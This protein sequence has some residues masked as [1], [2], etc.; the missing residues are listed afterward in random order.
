MTIYVK[1]NTSP[2][3]II[4][5]D[6]YRAV[7]SNKPQAGFAGVLRD[8]EGKW[9]M[10]C[11]GHYQLS[12]VIDNELMTLLHGLQIAVKHNLTPLEIHMDAQ[13]VIT[14]LQT[15]AINYSPLLNDCKFLIQQLSNPLVSHILSRT[16]IH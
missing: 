2:S 16:K 8:H 6:T 15:P 9:I 14:T 5:L 11:A 13:E 7:N 1:W 4:R 12:N 3:G 10:G